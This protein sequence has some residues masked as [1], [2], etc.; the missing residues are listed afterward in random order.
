MKDFKV[1]DIVDVNIMRDGVSPI[2][3]THYIGIVYKIYDYNNRLQVK[4]T[5]HIEG[6]ERSVG[7]IYF[8]REIFC[9]LLSNTETK[10]IPYEDRVI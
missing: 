1:G 3:K 7:G 4:V 10:H 6:N 5:Q 8:P 9:T 2:F